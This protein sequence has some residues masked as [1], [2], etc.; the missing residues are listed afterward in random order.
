[1]SKDPPKGGHRRGKRRRLR[2]EAHVRRALKELQLAVRALAPR[3]GVAADAELPIEAVRLDLRIPL[4]PSGK[5]LEETT[6][7]ALRSLETQVGDLLKSATAYRPGH[8]YCF[9]CDM[10]DCAHSMPTDA[11]ETFRGYTPNGKP[12]W[13]SFTNLCI[14]RQDTRVDRIFG[15]NPEIIAL[16]QTSVELKESLLPGFGRGSLVY[17]VLGQAVAGL[18]PTNLDTTRPADDRVTLTLQI[19]ETRSGRGG[20]RLHLNL[21][22]LPIDRITEAVHAGEERGPAESLRRT[23]HASRD[24]VGALARRL[25]SQDRR[26][27]TPPNLDLL[28][29]PLL[30]R[31]RG[32]LE[33]V[34][35]PIRRR[36]RHAHE[37]HL[38]GERPTSLAHADAL[39]APEAR[40]LRDT[41]RRTIVVLGPRSRAHV[42]TPSGRHVTSLQLRPGEVERKLE[43]KRW[44]PLGAAD[45]AAFRTALGER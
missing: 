11:R 1:M 15:D 32:D 33:R 20:R 18:I 35:R 37:R 31:L 12:E 9:L 40:L 24:R 4:D 39:N 28:V 14:E 44:R 34:F 5:E 2:P 13:H 41:E 6:S 17:N 43:R 36:T 29:A 27:E 8:V 25:D 16:V 45:T 38:G 26:G 10:P 21:F 19:V 22:G 30:T 7:G 42:F 3:Y 23:I